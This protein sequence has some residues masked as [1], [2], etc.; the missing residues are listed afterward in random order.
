MALNSGLDIAGDSEEGGLKSYSLG[1]LAKNKGLSLDSMNLDELMALRDEI[2][3]KLPKLTLKDINVEQEVLLQYNRSKLLQSEV[4]QAADIP[5]NQRVSVAN[6]VA[7]LLNDI[8]KMQGEVYNA[9]QFRLMEAALAKALKSM[10]EDAQRAFYD[11]YQKTAEE[12]A[13][14]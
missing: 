10:P 7:R 6:G 12:M 2:D 5:A 1:N 8:V 3:A 9:E 14:A 4:A 11:A 13:S